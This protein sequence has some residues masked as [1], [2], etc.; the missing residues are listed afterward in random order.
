MK[1]KTGIKGGYRHGD[2]TGEGPIEGGKN[3]KGDCDCVVVV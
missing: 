1:V 2:R 3:G